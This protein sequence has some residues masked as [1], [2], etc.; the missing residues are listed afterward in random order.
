MKHLF[1]Q[2]FQRR[3]PSG[4][5]DTLV[6]FIASR[7]LDAGTV[8]GELEKEIDHRLIPDE[9]VIVSRESIA[10][11]IHSAFGRPGPFQRLRERLLGATPITLLSFGDTGIEV[12]RQLL[13]LTGPASD[14][15]LIEICRRG[16]NAIFAANGGFVESTS[17]YH[18]RNPSG[19]HTSRFMRLSNILVRQTEITFIA[20]C[21]LRHIP[22]NA[23]TIYVDTPSLF[24]VVA[25]LNDL[26]Q[27]EGQHPPLPADSFR[28]YDH[29]RTYKHF[30]TTDAVALV[31][32]S[33]S[34]GL[35]ELLVERGFKPLSIVHILFLGQKPTGLNAAIDLTFHKVDNPSGI[36]ASPEHNRD[37]DCTLCQNGSLPITL[38][39][40]QFDIAG[41]QPEPLVITRTT[42]HNALRE[43]MARHAGT[44]TFRVNGGQ[45]VRQYA[46]DPAKIAVAGSALHRL[47]YLASAKVPANLQHCIAV[48]PD[49][50]SFAERTLSAAGSKATIVSPDEFE[51]AVAD[52]S[53]DVE[54]P[55]LVAAAIVGSGRQ[56]LDVSRRLRSCPKA[57][58]I[59]FA[60]VVTTQ[61]TEK[62]KTLAS[63]LALTSNPS[64]HPLII[65][66]EINLPSSDAPNAWDRELRLLDEISNKGTALGSDLKARQERLRRTSVALEDEI[67]LANT[68]GASL[69]LKPG[70]AFWD[71]ATTM[72]GH[73]QAD[74]FYTISAV[75]Q[76]LRT[77]EAGIGK[78]T[79]RTEWF[80][81][82]L[83][84]PENFGRFNDAVIQASLLRA[85]RPS[86]LDY[87][88]NRVASADAGRLIRR[89]VESATTTRGEAA[90]E[91]LIALAMGRLRLATDDLHMVLD[92]LAAQTALVDE[93]V[94]LC[95]ARLL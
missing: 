83:L 90:A 27:S 88:D 26:R 51:R 31:S 23:R 87:T 19:R 76:G 84:S 63:S 29:V 13:S 92:G 75:L 50:K 43:M 45:P 34:G 72:G 55:I 21:A 3:L 68:T 5:R 30:Q 74:V 57:P 42:A 33:S 79:L 36:Q 48:N 16:G 7:D 12:R 35:A 6:A 41:P 52:G 38:E 56:L 17:A 70:F 60:G 78:K 62:T 44:S 8:A 67:F 89:I 91:F 81:R 22:A 59:Y 54:Q 15:S 39:G 20:L 95:R 11:E 82:T 73:S 24:A 77:A 69:T 53:V 49:S 65:V 4:Y 46:V 93:L 94:A 40:D 61:S 28:S 37:G 32:A 1:V 58:I 64:P 14:L 66:D 85:A 47:N 10:S 80:Y 71:G 25:A 2:R 9:L 18:F 86:E